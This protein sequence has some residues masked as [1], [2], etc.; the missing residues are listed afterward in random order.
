MKRKKI[1]SE[2]RN[3]GVRRTVSGLSYLDVNYQ[4]APLANMT[5][6]LG[7]ATSTAIA[8]AGNLGL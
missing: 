4:T 1:A 5:A 3:H 7:R 2:A 6:Y 8:M